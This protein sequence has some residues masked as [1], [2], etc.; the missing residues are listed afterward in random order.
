MLHEY[1]DQFA[2]AYLNDIRI[3]SKVLDKH[4]RRLEVFSEAPN[5]SNQSMAM[6][7]FR[8]WIG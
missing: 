4:Q 7:L 1:M 6:T 5:T 3:Y 2:A 8:F